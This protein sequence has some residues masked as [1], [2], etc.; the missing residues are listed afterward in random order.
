VSY[1]HKSR[2][3]AARCSRRLRWEVGDGDMKICTPSLIKRLTGTSIPAEQV[4]TLRQRGL[5]PFICPV[6]G[7]P[8]IAERVILASMMGKSDDVPTEFILN[9]EAFN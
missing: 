1:L 4:A 8:F 6:T 5:N 9:E 2:F 7:Q 3:C